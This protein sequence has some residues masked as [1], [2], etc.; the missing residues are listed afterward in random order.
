MGSQVLVSQ[1]GK[2]DLTLCAS[3]MGPSD[4]DSSSLFLEFLSAASTATIE[5]S[6]S[7]VILVIADL[8]STAR[9]ASTQ[10]NQ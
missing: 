6:N 4:G 5:T 9:A 8:D 3:G 10:P 1:T 7:V 2:V